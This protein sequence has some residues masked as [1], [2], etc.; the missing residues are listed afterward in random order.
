[1]D[2]LDKRTKIIA[3]LGPA[4]KTPEIVKA[5]LAAGV[6]VFRLNFSHSSPD[7]AS[8]AISMV[9]SAR[10]ELKIPAAIMADI[11]GPAVRVYGYAEALPIETGN[12]LL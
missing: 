3:T 9:R 4:S 1:M 7:D 5:L 2:K 12:F 10:A 8:A 11:K 6:N